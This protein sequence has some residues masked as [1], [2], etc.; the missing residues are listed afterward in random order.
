MTEK[1]LSKT[2]HNNDNDDKNN[3]QLI[4]N[5]YKTSSRHNRRTDLY[6]GAADNG[7]NAS[8]RLPSVSKPR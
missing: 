2:N 6:K 1:T 3:E 7:S 4:I 5:E 8:R